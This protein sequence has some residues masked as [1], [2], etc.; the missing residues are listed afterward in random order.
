M[1][2]INTDFIYTPDGFI[3][4]QAVAFTDTIQ[5]IDTLETL[6]KKYPDAKVIQTE[7]NSI[8][9]PGFINTHV[10]LEFSANK[11]SLQYGSFMPWLDSVIEHR[12]DLMGR[13]ELFSSMN[14]S[15]PMPCMQIC[16]M[17]IL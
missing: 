2:I 14:S 13:N 9:Y 17:V 4:D 8:L 12:D 11:T 10:H 5:D 3:Q 6:K 1:K 7:E 16:F 15:V